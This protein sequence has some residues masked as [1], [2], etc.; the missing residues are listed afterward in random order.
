MKLAE[1]NRVQL[2]WVLDY[3]G[4]EG[5]ETANQMVR[6]G[7]ERPFIG[8]EPACS[9]SVGTAKKAVRDWTHRDHKKY[10]GSLTGLKHPKGFLQGPSSIRTGELLKRNRNQL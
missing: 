3:R 7:S 2:I 9:I 6:L 1:H 10:C 4:I 5:N 8:P